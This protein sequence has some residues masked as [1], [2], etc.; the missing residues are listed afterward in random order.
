MAVSS[1]RV[2]GPKSELP[3]TLRLPFAKLRVFGHIR[4]ALEIE[5]IAVGV[6]EARDPEAVADEGFASIGGPC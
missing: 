2:S 5:A 4:R 3:L 1:T 6:G